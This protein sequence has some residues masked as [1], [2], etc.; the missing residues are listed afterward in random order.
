MI[1]GIRTTFPPRLVALGLGEVFIIAASL[2]LATFL[3]LRADA[4][5]EL[6]YQGGAAKIGVVC[7]ICVVCL[8]FFDL[9]DARIFSNHRE[10]VSRAP[11]V[12]GTTSILLGLLYYLYPPA[13]LGRGIFVL[14]IPLLLIGVVGYRY[15]FVWISGH[16]PVN[17]R[18]LVVGEGSLAK[19]LVSEIKSRPELGLKVAGTVGENGASSSINSSSQDPP[20][21]GTV[22]QL[23]PVVLENHID[24][25]VVAMGDRRGKLPVEELLWLKTRGVAV[26]EGVRLYELISGKIALENLR[27][28]W[29]IFSDG[30]S[31]PRLSGAL[32]TALSWVGA[33]LGFILAAPIMLFTAIL[34]R[35][36]SR[37]P[38]LYRQVRVGRNGRHFTLYKFRS[39][40]DDAEAVTGPAFAKAD[41]DRVTR[42]GWVL[43]SL[44]LDE[45]P[46]LLNVLR[47]EMN[48]VGPR[49]E[50][51]TFVDELRKSIPFYDHRHAIKPGVTG[52]AQVNL[53]YTDD[54]IG[55]MEKLQYDLFYCKNRSLG[56]DLLIVFRT[57]KIVLLGRGAR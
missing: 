22:A 36:D 11:Q 9:Y 56:L 13:G 51:P 49:P 42:V 48:L 55:M 7:F 16:L 43:R 28:G 27:P 14:G 19:Q 32:M 57:V 39:M 18:L 23:T 20:E 46:Q 45:L 52:W 4:M 8:Y 25:V 21:L 1:R 6:S 44:R 33:L 37:G 29:L 12:I 26:E 53:S 41:D 50:R 47:G 38:V 15:V 40:R 54:E 2:I 17:E 3:R 31:I 5:F 34:I 30:F 24:R 10:L 35:M